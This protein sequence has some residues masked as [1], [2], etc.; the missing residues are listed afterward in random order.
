MKKARVAVG[1][2]KKIDTNRKQKEH[3]EM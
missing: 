3:S 2:K 1:R